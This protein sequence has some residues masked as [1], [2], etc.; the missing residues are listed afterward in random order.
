MSKPIPKSLHTITALVR[1]AHF[2]I[3]SNPSGYQTEHAA[4]NAVTDAANLLGYPID[5]PDP[6]ELCEKATQSLAAL[7]D[8][9]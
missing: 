1:V 3:R 4:A 6:A 8:A 2:L 9:R 7:I 5:S